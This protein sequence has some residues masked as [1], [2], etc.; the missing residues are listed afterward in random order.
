MILVQNHY[1]LP[2]SLPHTTLSISLQHLLL[3]RQ[4]HQYD[5]RYRIPSVGPYHISIFFPIFLFVFISLILHTNLSRV[6]IIVFFHHSNL[7][8][9]PLTTTFPCYV[10]GALGL[11]VASKVGPTEL[12]QTVAAFHSLVGIAAAATS[13]G[14]YVRVYSYLPFASFFYIRVYL[15]LSPSP[16]DALIDKSLFLLILYLL[17]FTQLAL[18]FFLSSGLYCFSSQ[19]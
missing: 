5:H 2:P 18:L 7:T 10:G 9:S 14:L 19:Y 6:C 16:I 12:P 8:V 17:V 3:T 13:L 1:P 15:R 11:G 4:Q